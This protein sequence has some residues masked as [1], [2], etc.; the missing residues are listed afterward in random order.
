MIKKGKFI[1]YELKTI[2]KQIG[3]FV[4]GQ[5]KNGKVI[6]YKLHKNKFIKEF[7]F[8]GNFVND[9]LNGENG[10]IYCV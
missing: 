4:N 8:I 9:K 6:W 1:L 3:R 5:F 10:K 7:E 2:K